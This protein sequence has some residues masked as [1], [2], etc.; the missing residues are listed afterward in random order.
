MDTYDPGLSRRQLLAGLTGAM[1]VSACSASSSGPNAAATATQNAVARIPL[2]TS[3][4]A[5]WIP[6]AGTRFSAGAYALVLAGVEPLASPGTRPADL[7]QQGFIASFDVVQGG[8]MPG[9]LVYRLSSAT[10]TTFEVFMTASATSTTR[11]YA[12]FN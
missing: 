1:V 5:A 9:D 4:V 3:E 2:A 12:L 6:A 8:F 7:R 10:T 11:M